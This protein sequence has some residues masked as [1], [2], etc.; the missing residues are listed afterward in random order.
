MRNGLIIKRDNIPQEGLKRVLELN[1][2]DLDL[3]LKGPDEVSVSF[4]GPLKLDIDV[5]IAAHELIVR[6]NVSYTL[7]LVCSRCL[8]DF[9]LPFDKSSILNY[10]IQHSDSVDISEGL[11]EEILLS[12]PLKPLCK[13]SCAGIC[14]N[15]GVN[16]NREECGCDK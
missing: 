15:C 4:S 6:F 9:K 11:R 2:A 10:N 3:E 8:D 16:L 14:L 7:N 12:Y 1:P 5:E 13:E